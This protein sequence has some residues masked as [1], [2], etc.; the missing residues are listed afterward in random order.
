MD[1]NSN[2]NPNPE[3]TPTTDAPEAPVTAAPTAETAAPTTEATPAPAAE[4]ATTPAPTPE[5]QTTPQVTAAPQAAAAPTAAKKPLP[6]KFILIGAIA[7]AAILLVILGFIFIP[8]LFRSDDAKLADEIFSENVLIAVKQDDKYGFI[9]LSGKIVI[10]PQFESASDFL[11]D[12]AVVKIKDGNDLQSAIIDRKGKVLL[13]AASGD[14]ISYDPEYEIWRVG[15]QLYNKSLKKILPEGKEIFSEDEGY[16]LVTDT[17]NYLSGEKTIYNRK[18]KAVYSYQST[19]TSWDVTE[20]SDELEQAYAALE[21]DDGR[22][23]IINADSGKVITDNLNYDAVWTGDYTDFCLY[24]GDDCSKYLL[25]WN[26]KIAKEY[27]YEIEVYHYG[28]GKNGYYK[29]YD[30]TYS[31]KNKHDTEYFNLKTGA[32]TTEEPKDGDYEESEDLTKWEIVTNSTIFSCNAGYGLMTNKTQAIPCEYKRIRTPDTVTYEY[33]KSKGKN[34]VIGN[35]SDKSYL[36]QASNGKVVTEFDTTYLSFETYSSF[37]GAYEE[38]NNNNY[39]VYNLVT[40][41]SATFE[42]N[43]IDYNPMYIRVEKSNDITEYYNKNFK[44]IYTQND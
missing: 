25:I 20:E 27:D 4:T 3:P 7:C 9:N 26:D 34:Y 21:I 32:I 24:D 15:D 18:G 12:K 16:Y 2:I 37:I 8:K 14:R 5:P 40:G 41:K 13:V 19:S 10:Q 39:H 35:K 1:P 6:K 43:D 44:L 28:A 33:L 36:L 11:G 42:A 30:D 29:I 22:Y 31:S 23:T 17:A 38:E